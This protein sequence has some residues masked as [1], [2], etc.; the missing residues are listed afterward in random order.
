MLNDDFIFMNLGYASLDP[1]A[2]E[3]PPEELSQIDRFSEKLY[4]HVIGDTN[5]QGKDV[6]EVGCGRGGG[7]VYIMQHFHPKRLTAV[8]I[9]Q[10][11]IERCKAVHNMSGIHFQQADAMSLPFS[12]KS[13]DA[14]IADLYGD[15]LDFSLYD[16]S[17]AYGTYLSPGEEVPFGAATVAFGFDDGG[18]AKRAEKILAKYVLLMPVSTAV[19]ENIVIV[20]M[21]EQKLVGRAEVNP[22]WKKLDR[23]RVGVSGGDGGGVN[24]SR[25]FVSSSYI[26]SSSDNSIPQKALSSPFL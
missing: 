25:I 6:L 9:A 10:R 18:A 26:L 14:V 21:D 20:E 22:L 2:D 11:A 16:I 8:D 15:S 12:D 24:S 7:S 17:A 1:E 23:E 5:I 3:K 19:F 13:F 4:H